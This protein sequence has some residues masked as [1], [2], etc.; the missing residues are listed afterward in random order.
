MSEFTPITTQ[1]AFDAAIG[2]R[3][4]RERETIT[5]KYADY[6]DLKTRAETAE[7]QLADTNAALKDAS[8]K[9]T[10]HETSIADLQ[11]K[12]KAYETD[13]VKTRIANELG[14]PYEFA[15]RLNGDEE[16]DIRKDA[17]G[18]AKLL[19]NQNRSRT[20][21]LRSTE[22]EGT[23]VKRAAM[24]SMLSEMKGE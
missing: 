24:R 3:L 6:D 23:D 21:P 9:L 14:I 2:E 19:G 8:E 11:K 13:S 10:S 22:P 20:Q 15:S 4:K 7:K 12:V 17:E 18:I 16:A 5:K 1:E